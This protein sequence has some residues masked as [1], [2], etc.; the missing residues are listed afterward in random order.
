[1]RARSIFSIVCLLG[2]VVSFRALVFANKTTNS[3]MGLFLYGLKPG[4]FGHWFHTG[5]RNSFAP[6]RGPPA[7]SAP[8]SEIRRGDRENRSDDPPP[9][10][11][12]A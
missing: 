3:Y 9:F 10:G 11:N 7:H 12:F 8:V 4:T 1:M 5:F 6:R 2:F